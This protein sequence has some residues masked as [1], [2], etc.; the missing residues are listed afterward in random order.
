[1]D[2]TNWCLKALHPSD[3]ITEVRGIPDH[4][5]SPTVFL[6]Y[7]TVA[8]LSAATGATG[9]WSF[10]ATLLPHP[11]QFMYTRVTDSVNAAGV[12]DCV[13]NSQ[14]D[15]PNHPTKFESWRQLARR[16]R[17][18]YM[19]VTCYQDGPALSDQGTIVVA[20]VPQTP[21]L[22]SASCFGSIN[23]GELS[24]NVAVLRHQVAQFTD[25]DR[26][27]YDAS[28][29]MPNA[30]FNNS[31][32]GAYVPLKLTETCQDWVSDSC[33]IIPASNFNDTGFEEAGD[34]PENVFARKGGILVQPGA[35]LFQNQTY[36]FT[37]TTNLVPYGS[38][39]LGSVYIDPTAENSSDM[40][41]CTSALCNG[42]V[43][44]ICGTNLS[45]LTSFSFFIR[46]GFEMQVQPLSVMSPHQKLSPKYDSLA[47][48]SYFSIARELKDAYPA[49]YNDLGKILKVI[50]DAAVNGG[51][52][53]SGIPNVYAQA[54]GQVMTSGG[55]ML[56]AF[57][58]AI[59]KKDPEE[60]RNTP[61]L[62]Q[63]TRAQKVS[64][65]TTQ[66]QIIR[67]GGA[68]NWRAAFMPSSS[69]SSSG[70]GRGNRR[71]RRRNGGNRFGGGSP[72]YPN[73]EGLA[74]VYLTS[75]R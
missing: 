65:A 54:I 12:Q 48:N 14:L 18:A 33:N 68:P 49:D 34:D 43:A 19:A 24:T 32:F 51:R 71:N 58:D 46:A 11:I 73:G 25:V 30:Y 44:H 15:G 72:L 35:G 5:A 21:K 39:S 70:K 17:L 56:S 37:G 61:S 23:T 7:Q 6:N 69:G 3:P 60:R 67:R 52:V 64:D 36:P 27:N 41:E 31:R 75:G 20:Q 8:H 28:Q 1:V 29:A 42:L 66:Q 26:P 55:P 74:K 2:G 10:D 47:L 50:G 9:V 57:G 40:G 62:S 59:H 22:F 38:T 53:L 45:V 63:I 4:D 13:L 16:W